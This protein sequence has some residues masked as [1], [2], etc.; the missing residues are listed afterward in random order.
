MNGVDRLML[1][2]PQR[3]VLEAILSDLGNRFA[4]VIA[5]GSRATGRARPGSDIDLAVIAPGDTKAEQD[6]WLALE[7]SDLPLFF[8]L[9]RVDSSLEPAMR[10]AI[11]RDGI[12]LAGS[13]AHEWRNLIP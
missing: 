10:R 13:S 11:L 6:L 5:Y 7:E 9:T 8:D 4:A 3:G 12:A 2:A 1:T